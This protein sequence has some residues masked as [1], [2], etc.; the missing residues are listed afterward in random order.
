MSKQ[1]DNILETD[2][3]SGESIEK[4]AESYASFNRI[5]NSLQR[6]YI[7]LKEEFSAQNDRLVET[8]RKL[9]EMTAQSI[10]ATDFLDSILKSIDAGVIAVNQNGKVT[11]FNP[12]ASRMLGIPVGEPTGKHYRDVIPVGEPIDSN[13]LRAVETRNEMRSVEKKIELKDNSIIHMSV[14]TALLRNDIGQPSGAVEVFHDLTKVKKMETEIARLNTLAAM[15]EMAATIA[16]QVRNP[17]AGIGGFAALLRR[18]FEADDP[19]KKTVDKIIRGVE[20]LNNTVTSLLNYT[21]SDEIFKE[22][23]ELGRFLSSTVEQ[24]KHE[25]A[26]MISH[27]SISVERSKLPPDNEIVLNLDAQLCSQLVNN[28]ITNA[29]EAC[30]G[31]GSMKIKYRKLPRQTA[32]QRYADTILLGHNDTVIELTFEDSGPGIKEEAF[33][34]LFA[35]FFTTKQGGNGLGLAVGWKIAKAHGGDIIAENIDGGGARFKILFPTRI[36]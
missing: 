9:I 8:N 16:H 33:E 6:Q 12:A 18:D 24:F 36:D 27:L 25:H 3:D 34:S 31:T 29:A 30:S 20:N 13:A 26:D 1:Q 28:L 32:C 23:I 5:V 7:E 2:I 14:S 11:H 19:R 4:F 17:L 22:E 10:T 35:P 15:G 21:R